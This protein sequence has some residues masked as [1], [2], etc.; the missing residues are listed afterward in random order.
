MVTTVSTPQKKNHMVSALLRHYPPPLIESMVA[1]T[2]GMERRG[3]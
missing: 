1:V 3:Q 2:S